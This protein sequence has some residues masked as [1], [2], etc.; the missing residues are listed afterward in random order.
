M[1]AS[2]KFTPGL[3]L[4]RLLELRYT[5]V[6]IAPSLQIFFFGAHS[7]PQV[8]REIYDFCISIFLKSGTNYL[9]PSDKLV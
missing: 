4:V 7:W 9:G 1:N 8:F 2:V 3:S 6:E 5:H